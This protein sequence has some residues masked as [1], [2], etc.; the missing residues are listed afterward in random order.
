MNNKETALLGLLIEGPKHAYQLEQDIEARGM[1]EWTEIG[2]SSIY[3]LLNKAAEQGWVDARQA[4]SAQGPPRKV[5]TLTDQGRGALREAV[6]RRLSAPEPYSGEFDLALAF[7]PILAAAE[8]DR[9]L[10]SNLQQ[11]EADLTRV[12]ARRTPGLPPHVDALFSHSLNAMQAERDW[13][14]SYIE[15]RGADHE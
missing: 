12:A 13:L 9:A 10:A 4:P 2:F 11:L 14:A 5:Y 3:Y 15:L 7:L 6:A 8:V 1:R